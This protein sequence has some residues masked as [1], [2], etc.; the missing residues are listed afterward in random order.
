MN[1]I[2][3]RPQLNSVLAV[4]F[5]VCLF[6][7][8]GTCFDFYYDL[9]DDVLIKDIVSGAYTGTPD[10]HSIQMLYP[11]SFLISLLYKLIPSLPWQ[12]IFLCSMH[13]ICFYLIAKRSLSFV[14]KIGKK[15]MLLCI[16]ALLVLTV[17]LWEMVLVQY[18][19]TSAL[20]AACACFLVFTSEKKDRPID[21]WKEQKTAV[22]LVILSFNIRSE[23]LLLM[24]PFIALTGILKWSCE[25]EV[26]A[27]ET[28]KK[29]LGLVGMILAGMVLSLAVDSIAYSSLEWKNFRDFFD[30]RTKVYDYTWY[31]DYEE[32]K[33]FYRE[34]GVTPAKQ[35]LIDNYNFGLDESID[36]DLLWKIA[37]YAEETGI[38]ESFWARLNTAVDQYKWRTFHEVDSPYN[39]LVLA[40]YAMV[41]ALAVIRRDK[42]LFFKLPLFWILRTIPWMYVIWADRVPA[43]ISHPLYYIE[44]LI[45][46]AWML[47][48]SA[49]E[50]TETGKNKEYEEQNT[51]T[52]RDLKRSFMLCAV[53]LGGYALIHL[54]A[55][56][57]AL[58]QE[59]IR[60]ETV[61]AP[62][63]EMD[64]YAA[65]YGLHAASQS[66]PRY[67]FMDVYST[68][69]FSEKM[70]QDVDNSQK[71][72]DILGGW[73]S[74]SPLQKQ[75]LSKY[76][77]DAFTRAELLLHENFYFVIEENRN[78]AFLSDFYQ[79][80]GIGIRLKKIET[81]GEENALI[82]YEV[83]PDIQK[84][85]E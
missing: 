4:L 2:K 50:D 6:S 70:F 33:D 28:W 82:V 13:G 1:R 64:A 62:M 29:Y 66:V 65:Q 74:G 44:F 76:H 26:F 55:S 80:M 15:A 18:T 67:Y 10:A 81:L 8:A 11:I 23:M 42:S 16:E 22:I 30:A 68:V 43:R 34:L 40:A 56:W 78:P 79:S 21:F 60:R 32:A 27:K 7:L 25:K 5:V 51:K 41:I 31:P 61:N 83:L 73:A 39:V 58:Q 72:Y 75:A 37:D 19:I 9:N 36:A 12:G 3:Y 53:L 69:G 59:M 54:P 63:E 14:N 84:A 52:V 47:S 38:Q 71:N 57:Q 45:L 49:E 35:E 17:F 48:Y 46:C 24:S 77:T 20:L 85:E